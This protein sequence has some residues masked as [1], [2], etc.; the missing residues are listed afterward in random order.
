MQRQ[1]FATHF[2][3]LLSKETAHPALEFTQKQTTCYSVTLVVIVFLFIIIEELDR[4]FDEI[5]QTYA[6]F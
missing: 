6:N 2:R 5:Q 4:I 3:F 1:R